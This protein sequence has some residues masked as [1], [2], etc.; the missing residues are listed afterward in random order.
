[1]KGLHM[2]AWIL[3]IIGGLNWGLA[4]FGWDIGTWG[5]G[6]VVDKIIYAL[7]DLAALYELFFGMGKSSKPIS[8][9]PGM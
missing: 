5:L 1:M 2:L 6:D 4:V 9:T 3:L 7:M 8:N